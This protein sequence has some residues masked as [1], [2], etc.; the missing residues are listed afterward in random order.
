[1]RILGVLL[2]AAFAGAAIFAGA[3]CGGNSTKNADSSSTA[4]QQSIDALNTQVQ[5]DEVL[6][7]WNA[8]QNLP[9]HDL[10]TSL[11]GGTI[12]GK[13]VPTL[14]TLIRELALT[15]WPTDLQEEATTF[16]DMAVTLFKG[17]NA[18]QTADQLKDA[19]TALHTEY[20]KFTPMAGDWAAKSLP[21]DAGGPSA[22][23]ASTPMAG[24]TMTSGQ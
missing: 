4:S 1:M 20:H 24:M 7:A 22:S 18:G 23:S 10:D 11:Q 14:R 21:A 13:F 15:P 17:L 3:A 19:S 6:N 16:H 5:Q 12:D 9:I 8:I 2:L